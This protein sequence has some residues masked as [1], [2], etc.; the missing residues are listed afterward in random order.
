MSH[1]FEITSIDISELNDEDLRSLI[2]LL[3]EA[4]FRRED[5]P[6]TGITLG[7]KQEAPDGGLDVVVRNKKIPVKMKM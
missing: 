7:G 1:V 4:D 5:L 6:T 3:C 2:G